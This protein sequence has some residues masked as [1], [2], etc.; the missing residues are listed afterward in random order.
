[1]CTCLF[2]LII[3]SVADGLA[4]DSIS[5]LLVYTD[6]G[7]DTITLLSLDGT[8]QKVVINSGL[9]QPRAIELDPL[10]G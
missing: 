3:A 9:D 2:L 5:R 7:T 8:K 6:A 10:N 4:V 1:M